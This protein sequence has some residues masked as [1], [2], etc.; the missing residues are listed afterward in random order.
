MAIYRK[1]CTASSPFSFPSLTLSISPSLS[2]SLTG[3]DHGE[4]KRR[5]MS[6]PRV[7]ESNSRS[8]RDLRCG[9]ALSI[10]R[11][12]SPL[13][14]AREQ[15][16]RGE[17]ADES[18]E[19]KGDTSAWHGEKDRSTMGFRLLET[20]CVNETRCW[21]NGKFPLTFFVLSI[22]FEMRFRLYWNTMNLIR[23]W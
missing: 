12:L 2:L 6:P 7:L 16:F 17:R 22:L 3:R 5:W 20:D 1:I 13:W 11:Y 18:R 8:R 21:A 19:L 14:P 15:A 10:P 9:R 4:A 23:R